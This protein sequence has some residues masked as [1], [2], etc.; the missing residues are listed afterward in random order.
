MTVYEA[1]NSAQEKRIVVIAY[2]LFAV[3]VFGLWVPSIA[4]VVINYLKI[5]DASPLY[6]SHHRWMIRTFWW[7]L[8]WLTLGLVL[9]VVLVGYAIL[10]GLLVWWIYRVVKGWLALHENRPVSS[11]RIFP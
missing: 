3:A 11:T 2:A 4:G 8:L 7:G 6:A 9:W 1:Q 5:D 10:G